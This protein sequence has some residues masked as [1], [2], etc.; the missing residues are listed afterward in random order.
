MKIAVLGPKGT[1]SESALIKYKEKS[2]VALTD[3]FY[4]TINNAFMAVGGECDLGIVPV[5]NTLDGYVQRSLDMLFS[6]DLKIIDEV[7]V[8]VQF[9]LVSNVT[10]LSEIKKVYV[11]FKANGQCLKFLDSLVGVEIVTTQS[12]TES[13]N[14]FKEDLTPCCAIIPK[15]MYYNDENTFSIENVT[16][17]D[18]NFTRFFIVEKSN[19]L[20]E[21][22]HEEN[23]KVSLYV[24][25]LVDRAGILYEILEKFYV[26]K[27]SLSSIISRPTKQNLGTYN[28]YIEVSGK[29]SEKDL[30]FE[31]LK[32]LEEQYS[33]KVLGMY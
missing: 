32:M 10:S 20:K 30:I 16:D 14:L 13:Y 19:S 11:Q 17:S 12:N 21:I 22:K 15:H 1:F 3:V 8:P 27:I 6:C 29:Y 18:N 24:L 7:V 26:N 25:P 4:P 33:L 9:S 2:S 31:T 5:E 23:I 28:F